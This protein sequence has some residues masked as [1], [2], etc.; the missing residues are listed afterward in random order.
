MSESG[1]P[2]AYRS[3][4]DLVHK[5]L[6]RSGIYNNITQCSFVYNKKLFGQGCV[7]TEKIEHGSLKKSNVLRKIK[8]LDSLPMVTKD[9]F[10]NIVALQSDAPLQ[11]GHKHYLSLSG[12]MRVLK[13][14]YRF[15]MV[16][17][18][19]QLLTIV[20]ITMVIT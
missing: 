15:W 17:L 10:R 3:L 7:Y 12:I 8:D 18:E 20:R 2:R 14:E 5:N 19:F 16:K 13:A 9:G 11:M 4:N 6:L 1:K